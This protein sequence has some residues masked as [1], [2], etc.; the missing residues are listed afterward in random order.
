MKQS[1]EHSGRFIAKPKT[2]KTKITL[3]L[4]LLLIL[5]ACKV[6]DPIA[7]VDGPTSVAEGQTATF[8]WCGEN[9]DDVTWNTNG[10]SGEGN[11][12]SPAFPYRGSFVINASGKN[13]KGKRAEASITVEYGKASKI[14]ATITNN[15]NTGNPN[16][17]NNGNLQFYKAYLYNN[18]TDWKNDID[19]YSHAKCIDSVTCEFSTKYNTAVA[20]FSKSYPALSGRIISIEYRP[21]SGSST[22]SNWARPAQALTSSDYIDAVTE[23]SLDN[24]SKKLLQGKWKLSSGLLNFNVMQL[25]VCN[26]DDY[27]KF[28]T[29][30][31]T[32]SATWTYNV[33]ADNCSG[34]SLPSNGNV[35]L[36]ALCDPQ[37]NLNL[38]NL[39]GPFISNYAT[40]NSSYIEVF[41]TS[42]SSSG[43]YKFTYEP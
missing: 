33:G 19:A 38:L 28:S 22:I 31:L 37:S 12:F 25:P 20:I 3:G 41:F 18:T 2:M 32:G 13:K 10:I 39:S 29:E 9:A 43:S 8:T 17:P 24:Y 21:T 4:A 34:S 16:I 27:L 15:C 11:S 14:I 35:Q 7:C 6:K 23:T 26:L 5:N 36:N 1:R 30:S 42:G 40:L